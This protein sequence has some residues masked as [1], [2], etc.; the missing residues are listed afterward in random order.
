MKEVVKIDKKTCES[1]GGIWRNGK[2]HTKTAKKPKAV[3]QRPIPKKAYYVVMTDEF[4]S[5][6]GAAK[7]KTNKLVIGCDSWSRAKELEKKAKDRSEMKYVNIRVTKPYYNKK[8]YLTSYR[9]ESE[10]RW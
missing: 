1:R 8:Y 4:M 5:G 2:C 3:T 7:G 9:N 10:I 6:W